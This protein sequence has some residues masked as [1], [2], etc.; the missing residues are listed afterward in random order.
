MGGSRALL[1]LL[2]LGVS[3]LACPIP[4]T[5]LAYQP[6]V[7]SRE[8]TH[9]G[10]L[11]V[12]NFGLEERSVAL[13]ARVRGH[14]FWSAAAPSAVHGPWVG[15]GPFVLGPR[16]A[17]EIP[18][19]LPVPW[20]ATSV[21]EVETRGTERGLGT[22]ADGGHL[23]LVE[24]SPPLEVGPRA[25]RIR[26]PFRIVAGGNA[27]FDPDRESVLVDSGV[28]RDDA[29]WESARALLGMVSPDSWGIEDPP[30]PEN[31]PQEA[32]FASASAP[33]PATETL[34]WLR[35]SRHSP[36]I[37]PL[38]LLIRSVDREPDGTLV[39]R[40]TYRFRNL[41]RG[42]YPGI[43]LPGRYLLVAIPRTDAEIEF[44]RVP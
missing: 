34:L 32:D 4:V 33:Y 24:P 14:R 20:N 44:R 40:Y 13:Q 22:V 41:G 6:P 15:I 38:R 5:G 37:R 21:L 9:H 1:S 25:G 30:P 39:C 12:A 19:D 36:Q 3:L 11:R 18:I 16:E 42:L 8:A 7:V 23:L 26:V 17:L 10:T 43:S 29:E 31:F 28:V 35:T 2:T 27:A